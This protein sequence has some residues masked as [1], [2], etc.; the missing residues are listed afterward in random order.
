MCNDSNLDLVNI[1]AYAKL[2]QH[3]SIL[4][5]DIGRNRNWVKLMCNDS[6]LDLVNINAY[7]KLGQ[8]PSILSQDIGRN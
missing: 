6:N 5:Q 1:N 4:S 7:A 2:G 8:N 3:P